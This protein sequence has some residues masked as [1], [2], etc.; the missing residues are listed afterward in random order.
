MFVRIVTRYDDVD[1]NDKIAFTPFDRAR[2]TLGGE[3]EFAYNSRLR[4]EWQRTTIDDFGRAPPPYRNAG[5]KEHIQMHMAS[6]IF[7]F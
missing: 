6:V 5:G 2:I 1:T 3:W 4:Y 7:A